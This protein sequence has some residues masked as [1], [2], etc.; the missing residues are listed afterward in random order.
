MKDAQVSPT[1][2]IA[3]AVLF[4]LMV[5]YVFNLYPITGDKFSIFLISVFIA[6]ML[7]PL[8]KH[9]KFFNVVDVIKSAKKK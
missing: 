8:V 9:L 2:I 1:Y 7:L 5:I 4:L 3:A 6:V